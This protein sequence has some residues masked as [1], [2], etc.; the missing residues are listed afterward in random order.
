LSPRQ[1]IGAAELQPGSSARVMFD[2]FLRG[3]FGRYQSYLRSPE[4]NSP[5]SADDFLATRGA[6]WAFLRYV[7]DRAGETDGTLWH[8]L[9]NSK[10]T[11]LANLEA[12]LAGTGLTTLGLLQDWSTSVLTDDAIAGGSPPFQPSWNFVSGMPAVGLA[13]GLTPA[14]LASETAYAMTIRSGGSSYLRFAVPQN[15]EALL[16]VRG[17]SGG[18]V[19]PGVRLTLVRTR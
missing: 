4:L 16:Q 9:V 5:I 8:R 15:G 11:G 17:I 18:A 12:E 19:P 3:N 13:F 2:T 1:N 7:A 14:A 10:R 6:T